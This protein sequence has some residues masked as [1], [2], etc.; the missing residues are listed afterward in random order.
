M[1][2]VKNKAKGMLTLYGGIDSHTVFTADSHKVA[3]LTRNTLRLLGDG[4]GYIA[5]TDQD[6]PFPEENLKTIKEVVEKEGRL[7]L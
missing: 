2:Y 6:L 5:Y 4:G 7:P 3:D 1:A